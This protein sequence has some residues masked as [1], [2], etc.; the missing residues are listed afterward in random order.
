MESVFSEVGV[1]YKNKLEFV[2]HKYSLLICFKGA[3]IL[4]GAKD[5]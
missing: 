5:P 4:R 3:C 2:V 1:K